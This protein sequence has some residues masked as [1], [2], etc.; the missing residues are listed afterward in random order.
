MDLKDKKITVVGLGNSGLNAA[1][2]LSDIGAKVW[3]TDS[4]DTSSVK[5]NAALL[6]KRSIKIEMGGHS[7]DFI[8]GSEL[9]VLSPCVENTSPVIKWAVRRDIPIISEME[10]GYRFCKGKIIAIT[11]TNGKSTVTTLIGQVLKDGGEDT[12]ACGN[13][14]NSLCGEISRIKDNTWVVLEV[15]S[16]QLERIKAFKPHIAMILNIT[17]DHMDRYKTFNEYFN[18]KLKVFYNQDENDIL[19]LNY[20]A[21]NLRSLKDKTTSKVLFYSR[22]KKTNGAYVKDGHIFCK[23]SGVDKKICAV[24]DIRLKGLYNLENVLASSLVSSLVGVNEGSIRNTIKSF[25][26]LSHRFE[27]VDIIDGIEYIDDS[28]GTTV[29][30]TYRALESCEKPVILIAGGKDKN[31]DY[32]IVRDMIKKKVR[33][34]IL[35]GEAKLAIKKAL[36]NAA[37]TEEAKDM[38]EAVKMAHGLAKENSIVLL[39]PMCS[40]F[41]MY[42]SYSQRGEVFKEAVRYIKENFERMQT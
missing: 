29:D 28:K 22:L 12:V 1:I 36:R 14:G 39:S 7:E 41:D 8:K 13:I 18:E 37:A 11:G 16:F 33:H 20:D 35:I 38:L 40:S 24:A 2:L 3:A 30:S 42:T 9:V 4:Q 23:Y 25:E 31:S 15:S 27:T 34:L 5:E 6:E 21:L 19:I 32:R 26:G 10:L 17:D